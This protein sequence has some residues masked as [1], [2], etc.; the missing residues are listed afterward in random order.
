MPLPPLLPLQHYLP[1]TLD[2]PNIVRA[3]ETY[4]YHHRLYM[5]LELC[6]G[7]DLYTREHYTE[8]AAQNIVQSLFSAIAY[9]HAGGITHRDVR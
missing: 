1:Q 7:G 2:H 5:V 3:I 8:A 9:L 4:D 6:S